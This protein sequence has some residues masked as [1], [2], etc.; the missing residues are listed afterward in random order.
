MT[1]M[2]S[3]PTSTFSHHTN[4]PIPTGMPATS[5]W[6]RVANAFIDGGHIARL[7]GSALR[8]WLLMMRMT[9]RENVCW[10]TLDL[11][12]LVQPEQE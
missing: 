8:V 2:E 10:P 12:V 1:R 3:P 7:S 4:T 6:F 9:N 5:G 11:F